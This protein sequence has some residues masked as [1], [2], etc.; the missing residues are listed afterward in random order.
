[1]L[2]A[3]YIDPSPKIG[4]SFL[5]KEK[6]RPTKMRRSTPPLPAGSSCRGRGLSGRENDDLFSS[7]APE[8]PFRAGLL[9]ENDKSTGKAVR[10]LDKIPCLA[11]VP[12][13]ASPAARVFLKLIRSLRSFELSTIIVHLPRISPPTDTGSAVILNAL[14]LYHEAASEKSIFPCRRTSDDPGYSDRNFFWNIYIWT[15]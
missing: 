5:Q 2:Y 1:M 13:L 12:P 9:C 4:S 11:R 15:D 14:L 3:F 7:R 8:Y 10:N 6:K